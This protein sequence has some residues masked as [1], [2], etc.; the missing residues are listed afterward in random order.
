VKATAQ[1]AAT[2]GKARVLGVETARAA[3]GLEVRIRLEGKPARKL[4][5]LAAP[6]RIVLDISGVAEP[7]FRL[8]NR[9]LEAV[10]ARALRLGWHNEA[11]FL[12]LVL[13]TDSAHLSRASLEQV[14]DGLVLRVAP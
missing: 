10:E 7:G 2:A 8:F 9:T 5:T 6:P 4:F 1:A 3:A 14:P 12:R 13:D 11:G